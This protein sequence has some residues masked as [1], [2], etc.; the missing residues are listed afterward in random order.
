[1]RVKGKV[2]LVTG[3][4]GSIGAEVCRNLAAEGAQIAALDRAAGPLARLEEE[5]SSSAFDVLTAAFDG[6]DLSAINAWVKV[7]ESELGP[8]DGLVNVAGFFRVEDFTDT[9]RAD[10]DLMV[11]A[12]LYTA[13]ASCRAVLPGMLERNQGSVVNFASTAG[14]YGSIR[15]SAAYSAAKGAVIAFSKSLAREVSPRGVRVNCVS[16]GPIDTAM[17]QAGRSVDLSEAAARTLVGRMGRPEDLAHAVTYLISDE[18]SFVTG[19]VLRVNG[20]SLI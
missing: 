9:S 16:P 10:W 3:A 2:V 19:D 12:N 13:M 14:E 15:P 1:M 6:S 8:V 20:G 17:F 5:F 7:V 4:A 18:S 11:T